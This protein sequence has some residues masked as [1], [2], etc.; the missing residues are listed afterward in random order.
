MIGCL[1]SFSF[2]KPMALIPNFIETIQY[3]FFYS[4]IPSPQFLITSVSLHSVNFLYRLL[5][6]VQLLLFFLCFIYLSLLFTANRLQNVLHPI[7]ILWSVSLSLSSSTHSLILGCII[8]SQAHLHSPC[9]VR[10]PG[11]TQVSYEASISSSSPLLTVLSPVVLR[12]VV[13]SDI[14]LHCGWSL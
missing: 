3:A 2:R 1:Y 12:F 6:Y 4:I 8:L 5:K 10:M 11:H 9:P 7:C 14:L 13:C